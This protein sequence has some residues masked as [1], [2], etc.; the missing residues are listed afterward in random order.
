[1][2]SITVLGGGI[3]GITTGTLL[4]SLGHSVQIVTEHRVDRL[5]GSHDPVVASLYPAASVIPHTVTVDDPVRHLR[6]A[7]AFFEIMRHAGDFG[8]RKQRHFEVFEAPTPDPEYAPALLDFQRIENAP[9]A[10]P[11]P[12]RRNGA[13]AVYGW[14]FR[15]YFA[16]TPVY[17]PRL[18]R[19]FDALGGSVVQARVTPELLPGLP[20][21]AV[22]DCLGSGSGRLFDDPRKTTHLRGVLVYADPPASGEFD[23]HSSR[24]DDVSSSNGRAPFA[25][26]YNYTPDASVYATARGTAAGVYAYPRSDVWVLGGTKQKGRLDAAGRWHG[27]PIAGETIALPRV[28]GATEI[29]VPEPL[30]SLNQDL[31]TD[32]TGIDITRGRLRAT[33]GYR[34][35][36]DLGGA[37]V[38]LGRNET[39]DG[40]L[41][42]HNT[43]HGGAGVTLSWSCA[44][45]V[46]SA[47]QDAG[48]PSP[49]GDLE[50]P[51]DAHSPTAEHR[52]EDASTA[53]LARSL[54]LEA[55]GRM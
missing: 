19:L 28:D 37:G 52:T 16:E 29:D 4:A 30:L 14:T 20:G 54:A 15:M 39:P 25:A 42:V 47:L 10:T 41:L 11:P 24:E 31:L 48:L 43:G 26:S 38:R 44:L 5:M 53:D 18:Y 33:F 51:G 34:Y 55:R 22:V 27:E 46:A 13:D 9:E 45:R 17:I 36:R 2:A 35:A 12:P 8:V 7:Q 50:H 49:R 1:M 3:S 32:W 21:D 40:R 23:I 6:D